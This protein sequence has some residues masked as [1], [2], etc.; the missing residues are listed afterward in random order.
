MRRMRR[1]GQGGWSLLEVLAAIAVIGLGISLFIKVQGMS[2]R[3][4]GTN[5]KQ[6][7]AGRMVEKYLE[8]MRIKIAS[9]TSKFPPASATVAASAPNFISL[10]ST[11][12]TAYSPKDPAEVVANVVKVEILC[13]WTMPTKDSLKVVTYV[14]KRF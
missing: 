2:S 9:D 13:K 3:G 4:S 7:V 5:S 10:Q 11:I 12:S 6:L 1:S 8:D 14:A